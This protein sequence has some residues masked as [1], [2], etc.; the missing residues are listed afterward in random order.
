MG[1]KIDTKLKT[2]IDNMTPC[3]QDQIFR[4]L[5][6]QQTSIDNMPPHE[7]DQI[8]RYLWSHHVKEDVISYSEGLGLELSEE[9]ITCIVNAY[10]YEGEYDCND[11]YWS[12]IENL[13]RNY[14]NAFENPAG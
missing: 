10:V 11:S 13:I 4:Y 6:S 14:T 7:Q 12:N 9:D 1:N 5:W 2:L 8:F 3:E